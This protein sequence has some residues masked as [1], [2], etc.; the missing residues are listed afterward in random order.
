MTAA[1]DPERALAWFGSDLSAEVASLLAE[2]SRVDRHEAGTELFREGEDATHF[3]IVLRGRVAL[4]V[5]VPERGAVTILTVEPG[6]II[7]WSALTPPFRST[8]TGTAME[9]VEVLCF[10]GAALRGLLRSECRLAMTV[11]PRLLHAV[12]RRLVATRE[13]LLDLF[14]AQGTAAW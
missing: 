4:S 9:P 5:L 11:Y 3:G 7:G 2:L 8:S 13:Q 1:S 10:E 14:A 12:S 6:D